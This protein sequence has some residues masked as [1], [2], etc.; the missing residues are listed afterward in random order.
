MRL[1]RDRV[2]LDERQPGERPIALVGDVEAERVE[3]EVLV[4]EL[5]GEL[6]GVGHPLDRPERARAA[7]DEQ[8]VLVRRVVAGDLAG[9]EVE[10]DARGATSPRA[11]ARG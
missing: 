10:R 7:D 1:D 2:A 6:V 5:V 4:L 8:L 11:A 9:L 3:V